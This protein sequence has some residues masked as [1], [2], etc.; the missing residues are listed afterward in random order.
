ML[1]TL[2]D[3]LIT[4]SIV[5]GGI[6]NLWSVTGSWQARIIQ[7]N[8]E[9]ERMTMLLEGMSTQLTQIGR[10]MEAKSDLDFLFGLSEDTP[11]GLTELTNSFVKFKTVG[12]DPTNGSLK[13]LTD[14]LA[15][16]GGDKHALHRATI[17]IQQ[18]AGKGVISMEELR[19]QLGEHVPRAINLMARSASMSYEMLVDKVSKGQ[20]ES[21]TAIQLMLDEF[22]RTFGGSAERMMTTWTGLISI[23]ETRWTKFQ[24]KIG[25][26]G[27]FET[28]KG[29][30]Q[31]FLM[32]FDETAID[33]F[34]QKFGQIMADMIGMMDR[35]VRTMFHYRS[36]IGSTLKFM[37][38]LI[39]V[40]MAWK[41]AIAAKMVVMGASSAAI[42]AYRL[43]L[44]QAQA[45]VGTLTVATHLQTAAFVAKTRAATMATAALAAMG[46][47]IGAI[48]LALG[49]AGAAFLAFGNKTKKAAAELKEFGILLDENSVKMNQ[50]YADELAR[51]IA[52]NETRIEVMNEKLRRGQIWAPNAREQRDKVVAENAKLIE[53]LEAHNVRLAQAMDARN[54]ALAGRS[55]QQK[56]L[57]LSR[58]ID[59]FRVQ[60]ESEMQFLD[61]ALKV[62]AIN[63]EEYKAQYMHA[64]QLFF[65]RRIELFTSEIETLRN[66][67]ETLNEQE[68]R[69]R[70]RQL[71]AIQEA[72]DSLIAAKDA[73]LSRIQEGIFELPGI[74]A[75]KGGMS[76]LDTW[77]NTM[78]G[79]LESVRA[80]FAGLNGE[81]AKFTYLLGSGAFGEQGFALLKDQER[82]SSIKKE[83]EELARLRDA[84]KQAQK[85]R[86]E[87]AAAQERLGD[88]F[89]RSAEEASILRRA[90]DSGQDTDKVSRIARLTS[91]IEK[92]RARLPEAAR[93][94]I[95]LQE[96]IDQLFYNEASRGSLSFAEDM[97]EQTR[98]IRLSLMR[99]R[100]AAQASYEHQVEMAHKKANLSELN[101]EDRARVEVELME[102]LAALNEKHMRDMETPIQK[103]A[104]SW[105]DA[106]ERMQD[107]SAKWLDDLTNRLADFVM[108]GKFN[109]NDFAN[110]I[111]RDLIRIRI[112]EGMSKIISGMSFSFGAD[113]GKAVE[114]KKFANGGIM[115]SEG[116][117]PLKAYSRGG[118]ANTP[119]LALFGEGRMPEAY[120]PLPDGKTIP[121]T[122]R[123]GAGANVQ[124]NVIN[125]TGMEVDAEQT[126]PRFDGRQMILD[127]VLTAASSPGSFRDGMRGAMR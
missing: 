122:M 6:R 106:A 89:A 67:I 114:P 41:I 100:Q 83:I 75:S 43:Q 31:D 120:V 125:Q 38:Y 10:Q 113:A 17:A 9:I 109:F 21:T 48:I 53:E 92:L 30:L 20:M 64:V 59:G 19:Q 32:A 22:E 91:E 110:S 16:F 29:M 81:V 55:A 1:P 63:R 79:N 107:A 77:L 72:R 33:L 78:R 98:E 111:I 70:L 87:A 94:A 101:A 51:K 86:E 49:V 8:A 14:A 99:E 102:Y 44:A 123:G 39:A 62:G 42:S 112:Q 3:Y 88:M 52:R 12:I 69:E 35:A 93:E 95:E 4:I 13:A 84:L 116:R 105:E 65:E 96:A 119:Q 85:A 5:K 108:T 46:G 68:R 117:L 126:A 127:V 60:Y 23:L 80:D 66:G 74:T 50:K 82:L 26:G 90:F 97:R 57:E 28:A 25:E 37:G 15:S 121:V 56:M 61:E 124:V 71:E 47:P 115:T 45:Q 24:L 27:Y 36:E 40:Y 104:R 76:K 54:E 2:R 34:G 103:L 18:M 11:F 118:I 7:T 58:T 73:Q